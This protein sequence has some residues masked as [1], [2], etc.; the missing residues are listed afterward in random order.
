MARTYSTMTP[1]GTELPS[2]SLPNVMTGRIVSD[3]DYEGAPALLVM[4]LCNHCPF[5]KHV[6]DEVAAFAR[7]YQ[8]R[9]LAVVG[10][11]A[12]DTRAYPQDGPEGMKEEAREAGYAFPYL[13][14][15]TQEVAK[16]F[17]AACTPD[18]FLFGADRRLAYRGQF[19]GSRPSNDVPITGEDLRT[20]TDLVLAGRHPPEQQTPSIGCNIKWKPGN[21]PEYFG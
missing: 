7:E 21:E 15:E 2:F 5:V 1:L 19:D 9:G 4:F 17:H 13:F 3:S 18:F 8:E 11:S 12:N 6:R 16:A 14:D 10:I 20:A